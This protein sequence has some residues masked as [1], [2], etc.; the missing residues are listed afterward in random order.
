MWQGRK[1]EKRNLLSVSGASSRGLLDLSSELADASLSLLRSFSSNVAFAS[2]ESGL[3]DSFAD[4]P[5]DST[6]G[7]VKGLAPAKAPKPKPLLIGFAEAW[8]ELEPGVAGEAEPF[9]A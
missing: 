7:L 5:G 1:G 4:V 9:S 3:S 8:L 6:L 2:D